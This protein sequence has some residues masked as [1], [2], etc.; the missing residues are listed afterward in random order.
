ML[1][2]PEYWTDPLKVVYDIKISNIEAKKLFL[3]SKQPLFKGGGGQPPDKATINLPNIAD[4]IS[5]TKILSD[6]IEVD[7]D[8]H[9]V[10]R[11]SA[12]VARVFIVVIRRV[13]VVPVV[14]FIRFFLI[15]LRQEGR[16]P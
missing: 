11:L 15:A 16:D 2:A 12:A 6:A 5:I 8:L 10:G 14:L 7:H 3:G 13:L 1:N 9:V 4:P